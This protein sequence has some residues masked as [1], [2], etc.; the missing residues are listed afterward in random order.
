MMRYAIAGQA[1]E[2]LEA[3]RLE[4]L[5]GRS[6]LLGEERRLRIATRALLMRPCVSRYPL[7]SHFTLHARQG[8]ITRAVLTRGF[9]Y[10]CPRPR[11]QHFRSLW[12]PLYILG[13]A[14]DSS[15]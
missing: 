12:V 7:H 11:R 1:E 14:L 10:H 15:S 13:F 6:S 9:V 3:E 2:L 8:G 5:H 4:S